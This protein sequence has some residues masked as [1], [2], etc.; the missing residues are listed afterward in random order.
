MRAFIG[1]LALTVALFGAFAQDNPNAGAWKWNAAKSS[2]AGPLP[3][4]VHNGILKIDREIFTGTTTP[5][6][7]RT[8]A[9]SSA[10]PQL[11]HFDLSAD[12]QTLTLTR[13]GADPTLKLVFDR[14]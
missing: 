13:P 9:Q 14:Q 8:A 1:V 3:P 12:G 2:G 7:P 10:K 4:L 5:R 11:F 6:T